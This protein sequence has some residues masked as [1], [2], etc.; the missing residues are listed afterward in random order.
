MPCPKRIK[1]IGRISVWE[2]VDGDLDLE[3]EK[4]LNSKDIKETVR[5]LKILIPIVAK[6]EE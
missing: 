4:T 3:V 1:C 5:M 2:T 6:S